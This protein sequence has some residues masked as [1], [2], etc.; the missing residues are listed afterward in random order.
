M[1]INVSNEKAIFTRYRTQDKGLCDLLRKCLNRGTS[2]MTTLTNIFRLHNFCIKNDTLGH[3]W[4]KFMGVLLIPASQMMRS[5]VH[6]KWSSY[7]LKQPRAISIDSF[8]QQSSFSN[9][10]VPM[11]TLDG[12]KQ[13]FIN[14]RQ[15]FRMKMLNQGDNCL[16]SNLSNCKSSSCQSQALKNPE[17]LYFKIIKQSKLKRTYQAPNKTKPF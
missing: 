3:L 17:K 4:H 6:K 15:A 12:S 14:T 7:Q 13:L 1:L 8:S 9:F 2:E 5:Q 16:T 10:T 11:S